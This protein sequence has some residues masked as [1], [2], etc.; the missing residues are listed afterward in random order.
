VFL[1]AWWNGMPQVAGFISPTLG[2]LMQ[3]LNLIFGVIMAL[4]FFGLI[5]WLVYRKGK[6]IKKY[7]EDEVLIGTISQE[8]LD[9]ITSYGG[10]LKARLSWRGKAGADFVAA[11]ARLA[12]SKWHTARAMQGQRHAAAIGC[13]EPGTKAFKR[14]YDASHRARAQGSIP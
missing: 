7:L 13:V 2:G 14:R 11:G 10:R 12:L 5:C 6:T 4:G 3:I 8:E 1:H 9:L